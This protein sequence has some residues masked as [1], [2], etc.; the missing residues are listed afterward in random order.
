[1]FIYSCSDACTSCLEVQ[2][3]SAQWVPERR[4]SSGCSG[5]LNKPSI[6]P[7]GTAHLTFQDILAHSLRFSLAWVK[8]QEWEMDFIVFTTLL[9]SATVSAAP[10]FSN[11]TITKPPSAITSIT[12]STTS[13]R[14]C[15]YS[16]NPYLGTIGDDPDSDCMRPGDPDVLEGG[17]NP[18][19]YATWDPIVASSCSKVFQSSYDQF[20]STGEVT[21]WQITPTGENGQPVNTETFVQYKEWFNFV[22]KE[23]SGCCLNCTLYGGNV[24]VYYW[25][26]PA[27]TPAASILVNEANFTLF[28]PEEQF[29]KR[30]ANLR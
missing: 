11:S 4:G 5:A 6:F 14:S 25:P 21:S 27:P 7:A 26:T 17:Y 28:V 1:V 24:Q 9:L 29:R 3:S 30:F 10:S 8:I 15:L 13:A 20:K 2:G 18:Y 12:S 22:P 19:V 23:G 16:V